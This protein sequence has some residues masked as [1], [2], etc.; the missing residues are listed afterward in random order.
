MD[1]REAVGR[2]L[3]EQNIEPSHL[4]LALSGGY[5]STALILTFAP[6]R[7]AGYRLSAVHINHHLRGMDSNTDERF[8]KRLCGNLD[9]PLRVVDGRLDRD[10]VRELGVEG[11]AR[12]FRYATLEQIRVEL[13]ADYIV[14]AH[15]RNDL[16]E[17][18][19]MRLISSGAVSGLRGIAPRSGRILRPMLEVTRAD[20]EALLEAAGIEPRT[21]RTNFDRR[22]L[23]NRVRHDVLPLLEQLNPN[24]LTALA[25]TSNQIRQ[26]TETTSMYLD[27]VAERAI[28]Q[29]KDSSDFDLATI[30]DRPALLESLL[31]REIRRLQPRSRSVSTSD[32]R[33]IVA[34]ASTM[35][36]ISVTKRLELL[37]TGPVL[38]LRRKTPPI[39][40][41]A[42]RLEPGTPVDLDAIS[43][44]VTL[45]RLTRLP[46]DLS[47]PDRLRQCFQV[48]EPIGQFQI[49]NRRTGDR[50]Q[51]LGMST[52]K[53]LNHFLI[54]RKIPRHER[55]RIPLL[56]WNDHIVWVPGVEVSE[57]FRVGDQERP[58]WEVA[59][60]YRSD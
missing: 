23:R 41:F 6:L 36:R 32:L 35:T 11:A 49:R 39:G 2:F 29:A 54:D 38:S 60:E 30:P 12:E 37:R 57:Q 51:P 8:V 56:L 25:E 22:F 47:S 55:D 52:E 18:V 28:T 17:T 13:G 15:Q 1:P 3:L 53:S 43:A 44:H 27:E 16:A 21:D 5:D 48:P 34:G 46:R 33:R 24:I 9:V 40:P 59:V 45:R 14:T 4:V 50:F 31:L 10:V 26:L 58:V 42:E 19:L 20:V 7:E